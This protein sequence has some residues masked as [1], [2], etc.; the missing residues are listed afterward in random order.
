MGRNYTEDQELEARLEV[1]K[2]I[3]HLE[4]ALCALEREDESRPSRTVNWLTTA[5]DQAQQ[6]FYS[7][8]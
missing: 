2:A 1:E 7:L 4:Q 3:M 5:L 8:T 6:A